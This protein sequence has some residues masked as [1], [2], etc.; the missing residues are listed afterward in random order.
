MRK[1]ILKSQ[2]FAQDRQEIPVASVATV[3]VTSEDANHPVEHAFNHHRGPG[4]TRWVAEQ[5]GEQTILV[6]FDTPQTIGQVSLEV[7]E[8]DVS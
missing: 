8:T 3:C 1:Q 7:E 6:V 4:G 5:V 2:A